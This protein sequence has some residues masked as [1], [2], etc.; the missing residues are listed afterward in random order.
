MGEPANGA[1]NRTSWFGSLGLGQLVG[2]ASGALRLPHMWLAFCLIIF[3]FI[4]GVV[5]N[6]VWGDRVVPGEFAQYQAQTTESFEHWRQA[7]FERLK[8]DQASGVFVEALKVKLTLFGQLTRSIVEL[9]LGFDELTP[10]DGNI[11]LEPTVLGS[12]RGLLLELPGW[13]WT[14]HRG[15]LIGYL[16]VFMLFWALFGGALSRQAIVEAATGQTVSPTEAIAF[17][18]RRRWHY[19]LAPLVPLGLVLGLGLGVSLFG[20]LLSTQL[21][22]FVAAALFIGALAMGAMMAL[23]LMGWFF[24]A[25]LTY[26]AISAEDTDFMDAATGRSYGMLREH[27]WRLM[28]YNVFSLGYFAVTYVIFGL[29]IFASV[30]L[31]QKATSTFASNHFEHMFPEP[32][33]GQLIYE[34]KHEELGKYTTGWGLTTVATIIQIQVFAFISLLGAYAIAFF[35]ASFSRIYL[36]LRQA[37]YGAGFDEIHIEVAPPPSPTGDEKTTPPGSADAGDEATDE[38]TDEATPPTSSPDS[39]DVVTGAWKN[40][41]EAPAPLPEPPVQAFDAPDLGDEQEHR[42]V[43]EATESEVDLSFDPDIRADAAS[44]RALD[45]PEGAIRDRNLTRQPTDAV[46]AETE[47]DLADH[48]AAENVEEDVPIELPQMPE[49]LEADGGDAEF[50]GDQKT[51]VAAEATDDPFE[52]IAEQLIDSPMLD[53]TEPEV[54]E[55]E[56]I[57]PTVAEEDEALVSEMPE[58]EIEEEEEEE[59]AIAETETE[60]TDD[61][62]DEPVV[63]ASDE[64]AATT[65]P[66]VIDQAEAEADEEDDLEAYKPDPIPE[67]IGSENDVANEVYET[68]LDVASMGLDLDYLEEEDGEKDL[69]SADLDFD[70]SE[71]DQAEATLTEPVDP[72]NDPDPSGLASIDLPDDLPG[73]MLTDL[74]ADGQDGLDTDGSII[75]ET[76]EAQPAASG[77]ELKTP[78]IDDSI[79]GPASAADLMDGLEMDL[80]EAEPKPAMPKVEVVVTDISQLQMPASVDVKTPDFD[81]SIEAP[82]TAADLMDSLEMSLDADDDDSGET[83]AEPAVAAAGADVKMPEFD[84]SIDAPSS[85]ADLMAGL[86]DEEI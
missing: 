5:M 72:S 69:Q 39:D 85:A 43:D 19:L 86:D 21:I 48:T 51:D 3:L 53:A 68:S 18:W 75:S 26:P 46:A 63:E 24:A 22:D 37:S 64:P 2:S 77:A 13:M 23:V 55:S 61:S 30:W 15:F 12:L 84:D 41:I 11:G 49:P 17:A 36:L 9:R 6:D 44:A 10:S 32:T 31:T 47:M 65:E 40:S 14:S 76:P 35:F 38:K 27:P 25:P 56:M 58:A 71:I 29:F 1:P 8:E 81:E 42:A 20:L 82:A 62:D 83:E 73:T 70:L 33:F 28:L 7:E 54:T 45:D 34:P 67:S 52:R 59:E 50:E 16:T 78:D 79:E 66:E 74:I 60:E 80:E 4:A 57:E